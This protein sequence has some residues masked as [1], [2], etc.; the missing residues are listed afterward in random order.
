MY[1]F[2]YLV[3]LICFLFY[4]SPAFS[5][6][7]D[8][9]VVQQQSTGFTELSDYTGEKFFK[10]VFELN[11]ERAEQRQQ[12]KTEYDSKFHPEYSGH[13]DY[14]ATRKSKAPLR[15]VRDAVSRK[16]A[17][18]VKKW[19]A[20]FSK[21]K[22]QETVTVDANGVQEGIQD[23]VQ[24]DN[25]DA[26]AI[27]SDV[28][29]EENNI[30][31]S[32]NNVE[33]SNVN[34]VEIRD[35]QEITTASSDEEDVNEVLEDEKNALQSMIKCKVTK[36]LPETGEIEG[37]GDV[38]ISFPAE[39][40]MMLSD[41]MIYNMS[42]GIIQLFDNVKIIY[43]GK[44]IFGDYM[45]F[46]MNDESGILK[47]PSMDDYT[48]NIVAENG[49]MFGDTII[50]ENGYLKSE[51]EEMLELRSSG[52]GQNL[53]KLFIPK[54]EL[55][56][57][58]NDVDN[59]KYT[60]KVDEI[61]INAKDAHDKITL[62]NPK[63]F[64]N[65]TGKKVFAL[66]SMTFYTN[67][68]RDYLEAGYPELGS[69]SEFGMYL[70]PGFVFETPKGST[71]KVIPTINYKNKFGFGGLA[72]F[73]SA[74]NKTEFGYN[75]A[76]QRVMLKGIQRL[77][78]H[79][80]FQYGANTYIDNWF[81]GN[82]WLG[83]GGELV[84]ERGF[85]RDNFLYENAD[86]SFRH[87]LSAGL[88]RENERGNNNNNYSGYHRMSTLR[89]KYMMEL[90]QTLLKLF[91]GED[92]THYDGWKKAKLSLITQGSAAVY[93]TGNTQFIGRIGPRLSTQY[94][95]WAQDL[96]FFLSAADDNTPLVSMDAYRY[97]RSNVYI[98]EYLRLNKYL[99]LGLYGSYNLTGSVY[100]YQSKRD[101]LR[102]AS[103]YLAFGPDDLK[104]NVGYD[105]I[106]QNT[107]FGFSM[108]MNTKGSTIDY[109]KLEIKNP[110]QFGKVKGEV[111]GIE[112]QSFSPPPSPYR[113]KAGVRD[114]EDTTNYVESEPL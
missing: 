94:K 25:S 86:L 58:V 55:S 13:F 56:F 5:I 75:T 62:K 42:S 53:R 90:D 101:K 85:E 29:N 107:Y 74:T 108:A 100:D 15:I 51:S 21:N 95:F 47:N 57:L 11:E 61:N 30:S 12:L 71:L 69:F 110:E 3:I 63:V 88:L 35:K 64:S 33:Q 19:N 26:K 77:D 109:K 20:K 36:Y 16:K 113:S 9:V 7:D 44:E 10:S 40:V 96:G 32:E 46:D 79:L 24:D 82:S 112:Q 97:G 14:L 49:Y 89:F 78:D 4:I 106:R 54:E 22:N 37:I 84:Y 73:N 68:E 31:N 6:E 81:L 17:E 103:V 18:L 66:P 83:K 50:A 102:E 87:R 65:K 1:K 76:A 105:F 70:G 45:K 111:S 59:N 39:K 8:S 92:R 72:R 23:D 52:F 93:G 104:L 114:L 80:Y 41:R 99:T 34:N 27:T 67:K 38:E 2:R 98:R 91:S 28:A 43:K 60:V 48:I